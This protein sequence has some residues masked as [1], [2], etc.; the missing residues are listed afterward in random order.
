[1]T[2]PWEW[3]HQQFL[4][5]A[6]TTLDV[7]EAA[8][9]EGHELKDASAFNILFECGRPEFC[10]HFSM[11]PIRRRYWWAYGQF[12]RHFLLPLAVSRHRGLEPAHVF[13]ASL[14]GL[15]AAS[16]RSMLGSKFWT[17]RIGI[18]LL[19]LPSA[20]IEARAA[21]VKPQRIVDNPLHRRLIS[22]LR[23]QLSGLGQSPRL[24]A[25]AS[26]E[27]TRNHYQPISLECKRGIVARWL[28]EIEP[29][30]VADLGCNQ[31]E[32]SQIAAR[33][34][35]AGVIA[36]DADMS[37]IQCLCAKLTSGVPIYTVCA[38]LDDLSGGRGWMGREYHGLMQRL[39]AQAD[40][41]MALALVHHLAIGRSIPLAEVAALMSASTRRYLIVEYLENQDPMVRELLI[42]RD[43]ADDSGFTLAAQR[44]AFEKH[45]H[46]VHEIAIDGS[47][48][49]LALLEKNSVI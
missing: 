35:T 23:W 24:S 4:Q 39:G 10:D 31:G 38:E 49:R 16:A 41:T 33:I 12:I 17:S 18:A 30:W 1:V 42:Y 22:F 15:S 46:T 9:A 14:D 45:F 20:S 13:R 27:R 5:A 44:H 8:L 21:M 7:A 26:Y 32:F 40:V 6:L 19:Q 25:W 47:T 11:Q 29:T 43:R 34:A 37:A 36:V 3:T 28:S 2:Y 48:R